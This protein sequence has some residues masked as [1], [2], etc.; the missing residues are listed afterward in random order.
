MKTILSLTAFSAI[1]LTFIVGFS[2]C[3]DNNRILEPDLIAANLKKNSST[4][5][6]ANLIGDWDLIK[7]AYTA[8]GNKITDVDLILYDI[9]GKPHYGRLSIDFELT[10]E[11]R[12]PIWLF[13]F[14]SSFRIEYSISLS[15]LINLRVFQISYDLPLFELQDAVVSALDNAYSFAV[16]GDEL[17]IHFIDTEK[18]NLLVFKRQGS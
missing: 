9:L 6:L 7:F 17:L 8:D 2:S 4:T 5:D 12:V 10:S 3:N 16:K 13:S 14:M 11:Q 18:Q 1:L 15:N